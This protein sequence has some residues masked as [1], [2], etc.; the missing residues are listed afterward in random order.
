MAQLTAADFEFYNPSNASSI[1][2]G[3]LAPCS[4]TEPVA[5]GWATLS[6]H[7]SRASDPLV[8]PT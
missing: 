1:V 6:G 4:C 2:A 8:E 3:P 5:I 7:F